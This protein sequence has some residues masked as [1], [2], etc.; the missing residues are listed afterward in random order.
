LIYEQIKNT[1]YDNLLI[2][3]IIDDK[4]REEVKEGFAPISDFK[5]L[6][7]NQTT[8]DFGEEEKDK[9]VKNEEF[10]SLVLYPVGLCHGTYI[11]C[12]N[13]EGIYLLD[14][15]AAQERVNYEHYLDNLKKEEVVQIQTLSR[16]I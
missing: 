5:N 8:F 11:V 15:H 13:D 12:E 10:K 2:P 1:L 16:K 14:Q 9:V 6:N 7:G 3:D 4:V